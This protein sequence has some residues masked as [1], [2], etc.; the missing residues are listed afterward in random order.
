MKK[1]ILMLA[2]LALL[3]ACGKEANEPVVKQT[4]QEQAG[5]RITIALNGTIDEDM[6]K[7]LSYETYTGANG[8]TAYSPVF[9]E[10][11][12]PA[13]LCIY[14]NDEDYLITKGDNVP[15][16]MREVMLTLRKQ[17]VGGRTVTTFECK[18]EAPR[19]TQ[20]Q[21][22]LPSSGLRRTTDKVWLDPEKMSAT[23]V[24]GFNKTGLAHKDGVWSDQKVA[25]EDA[26]YT[27]GANDLDLTKPIPYV[28]ENDAPRGSHST[29]PVFVAENIKPVLASENYKDKVNNHPYILFPNIKLKMK[30]VILRATVKNNSAYME[31]LKP[32][33]LKVDGVGRASL[34]MEE[35]TI[36]PVRKNGKTVNV[37]LPLLITPQVGDDDHPERNYTVYL[38]NREALSRDESRE[39]VIYMPIA[40][41]LLADRESKNASG[42]SIQVLY[43]NGN[44]EL[45]KGRTTYLSPLKKEKEGIVVSTTLDMVGH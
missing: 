8:K 24:V 33:G 27:Y 1:S 36:A 20:G 12:I 10:D 25:P 35:P 26:L 16:Q 17:T 13:L 14:N 31:S 23:L 22:T 18:T 39:Y 38:T 32:W 41:S 15:Y 9:S 28:V 7:A 5:D 6:A 42:P 37:L 2:S 45:I 11:E 43:R 19:T 40:T 3:S 30:G 29:R 44:N 4:Q 34:R 21:F